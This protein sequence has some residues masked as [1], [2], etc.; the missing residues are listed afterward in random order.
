MRVDDS[1]GG[2][3]AVDSYEKRGAGSDSGKGNRRF[4]MERLD[5][6]GVTGDDAFVGGGGKGTET[7]GRYE[8]LDI[9]L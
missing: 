8:C 3:S 9:L 2:H 6:G 1:S 4:R 7:F 5:F